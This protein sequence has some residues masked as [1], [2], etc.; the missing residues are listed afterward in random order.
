MWGWMIVCAFAH[1]PTRFGNLALDY[2]QSAAG[3]VHYARG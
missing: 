1:G 3:V 2:L